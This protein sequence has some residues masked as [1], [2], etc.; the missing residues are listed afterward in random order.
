MAQYNKQN[1][2]YVDRNNNLFDVIMLENAN[3]IVNA[4]NPLNV[5]LGSENI[6][7]T[8]NVNVGTTVEISNDLGNP[9][10][11]IIST[12]VVNGF[13]NF[14]NFE[15]NDHRGF[16]ISDSSIPVFA[17]RVKPGSEKTFN[18]I[19][20]SLGN[21]NAD[22]STIGYSWYNNPTISGTAFSWID[23]DT[24]GIQYA[25]FT[26]AYGT[27]VP[28][29]LSNGTKNHSGLLVGKIGGS[30]T[31]SMANVDFTDGGMTMVLCA[32]RLDSSTKIDFWFT[33]TCS[34]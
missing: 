24:T 13:Y 17:V 3:G 9:I 5:T 23:I 7:I 2:I 6:T 28:N 16:T 26:D 34:N 32:Q 15:L 25:V 11:V 29:T 27:N 30:I 19:E 31:P 10:P 12:D 14:N 33:V 20:Y 4:D 8:G 22:S 18:L 21:N 1:E